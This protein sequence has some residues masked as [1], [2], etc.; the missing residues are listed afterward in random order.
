MANPSFPL[1]SVALYMAL[2]AEE[3]AEVVR[4]LQLTTPAIIPPSLK[5]KEFNLRRA[6]IEELTDVSSDPE[7]L[8]TRRL[9]S[10]QAPVVNIKIAGD[11]NPP[12]D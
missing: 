7:H 5:I 4:H 12:G 1:S 8:V 6:K 9:T 3:S 10:V 11:R 2:T